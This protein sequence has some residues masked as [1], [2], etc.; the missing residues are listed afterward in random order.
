MALHGADGG[1]AGDSKVK[2]WA[3]WGRSYVS[4]L[5]QDHSRHLLAS[6][7]LQPHLTL[8]YLTGMK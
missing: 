5:T 1:I 3:T 4:F 6:P 2:G 8:S 7:F